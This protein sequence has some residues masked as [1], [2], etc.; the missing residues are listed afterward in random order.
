MED[1][2]SNFGSR[3]DF[4]KPSSATRKR[5]ILSDEE[6]SQC[7][8]SS[9]SSNEE[10]SIDGHVESDEESSTSSVRNRGSYYTYS[11]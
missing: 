6:S 4:S 9:V 1:E 10:T 11:N 2:Q 7:T 8:E 5:P 3:S